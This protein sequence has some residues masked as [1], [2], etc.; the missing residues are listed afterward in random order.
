MRGKFKL[1][2]ARREHLAPRTKTGSA[3]REHLAVKGLKEKTA[4]KGAKMAD[5]AK[6]AIFLF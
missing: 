3:R 6:I 2:Y 4:F 1:P 5:N